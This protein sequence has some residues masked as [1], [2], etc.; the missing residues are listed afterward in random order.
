MSRD[1]R[2]WTR[3]ET[4]LQV[5]GERC[6]FFAASALPAAEILEPERRDFLARVAFSARRLPPPYQQADC[7][8][9]EASL[10]I[11]RSPYE[12]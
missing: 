4:L 11:T 9:Q 8:S 3:R 6:P 12:S 1:Q 10:R 5:T 7:F 2:K